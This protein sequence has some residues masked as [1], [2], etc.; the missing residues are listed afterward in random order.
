MGVT[1]AYFSFHFYNFFLCLQ[2]Q[3]VTIKNKLK[4]VAN[5]RG[6]STACLA[7]CGSPTQRRPG[8]VLGI[9]ER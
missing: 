2:G 6:F 9:L 1:V 7:T 4:N 8:G 3:F 5:I